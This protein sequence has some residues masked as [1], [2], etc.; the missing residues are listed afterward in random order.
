MS[1]VGQTAPD[2]KA[3]AYQ[4]DKGFVEVQLSDYAKAGKWVVMVFYPL[5]FTFVCP[6]ELKAFGE[7]Y[8]DFAAANTEVLAVSTDSHH[9]HKAWF[10]RD[11]PG[12]TYPVVADITKQISRNYGVLLEDAGYALRGTFII[13]PKGVVQYAVHSNTDVGRGTDETL[14]V[15]AACQAGGLCPANWK[16]G[17]KLLNA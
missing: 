9:S 17:E 12:V 2:F 14:R 3:K 16:K 10:Q 4:K 11:L 15:L 6:T 13:D 5:D 8:A 1:L 7:V